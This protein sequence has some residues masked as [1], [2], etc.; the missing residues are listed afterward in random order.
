ME[1]ET[2]G[3]FC[4]VD[5]DFTAWGLGVVVVLRGERPEDFGIALAFGPVCLMGGRRRAVAQSS[6]R[7][8]EEEEGID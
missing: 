2:G 5:V 7:L 6:P 3:F 4:E 1:P 8:L